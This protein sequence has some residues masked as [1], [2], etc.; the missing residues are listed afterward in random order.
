MIQLP[1]SDKNKNIESNIYDRHRVKIFEIKSAEIKREF[2]KLSTRCW[3]STTS[4]DEYVSTCT[5][6]Y[7]YEDQRVEQESNVLRSR[8]FVEGKFIM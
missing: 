4:T 8:N 3:I 5:F 7:M 6:G 2:I 1:N